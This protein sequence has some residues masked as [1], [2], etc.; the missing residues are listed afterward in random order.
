MEA[1]H[2]SSSASEDASGGPLLRAQNIR[3]AHTSAI[4]SGASSSGEDTIYALSSAPG[5]AAISVVRISGPA[6]ADIYR[7]LCPR[8][9]LPEPRRA[10]VR[11]LV[12]PT[13][14]TANVLDSSA[15]ILYFPGPRTA[16]GEDILE[17]HVH[18]GRATVK[19]I[20]SAIPLAPTDTGRIRYA[21][22]G[23]F[24]KRAFLND[25][26]DL[27]QI[28]ALGDTLAAETEQQRRAAERG[29]S[30]VLS[31]R[32][33]SWREQ[34]LLARGEIEALIDFSEDQHFDES[35]SELLTNVTRLVTEM[36]HSIRLHDQGCQKSQLL[37]SGIRIALLGPPNVGKS[38]LMNQ[39]VGKEASIVSPEAGTT[40]DIVEVSL[41]MRGYLCSFAD[42]AG[43][44]GEGSSLPR[45][46]AVIGHVER[47]GIRRARATALSS[48]VVVVLGA[49]TSD[50][51][52]KVQILFDE[53][54]LRLAGENK[55]PTI[56]AVNKRDVANGAS[57]GSLLAD[58]HKFVK[59][60]PGLEECPAPI[61]ISCKEAHE[62][63]GSTTTTDPGGVHMLTDHLLGLFKNMT[64]MPADMQDL[65]GVTERQRQLLDECRNH[66]ENFIVEA[67]TDGG[68]D[69]DIVLAAEHLRYAAY[70]LAKITGR[71]EVPDVEDVLGV[72]F[73]NG[74]LG[75]R[76]VSPDAV[77]VVT[78]AALV[79]IALVFL[80]AIPVV[81]AAAF[82]YG[83][84]VIVILVVAATTLVHGLL[85]AV[86][87]V[88]ARSSV[89]DSGGSKSD[90][91]EGH[92]GDVKEEMCNV[93]DGSLK[94]AWR[95]K[96]V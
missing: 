9:P 64:S 63:Q 87:L 27:T 83:L 59:A 10:A 31:Q 15:L 58:F 52:G 30:Q 40:R 22:P 19:S 4:I 56:V 60:V 65:L 80:I 50:S 94:E 8:K 75:T 68:H 92:Y 71:G 24:T 66:L 48:D 35:P 78:A 25:R 42:T 55:K 57:I 81:A 62:S 34:L 2:P 7:A 89:D 54:I 28:D 33:E 26:L 1:S 20:L 47:E 23:E 38:S 90:S 95:L 21:E 72:I 88:V 84:L 53:E 85:I 3:Q 41:D 16:T 32:Y 69:A 82:G 93:D 12:H 96:A 70:S 45:E 6:A 91:S 51:S 73:E 77:L 37:R 29:N 46:A 49:L 14:Q 86:V 67:Q 74:G 13:E 44:R 61:A 17:L 39:I 76:P 5:R 79:G 36:L 43:F 18:G 11:T